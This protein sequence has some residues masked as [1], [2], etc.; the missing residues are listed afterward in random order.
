[1]ELTTIIFWVLM[2]CLLLAYFRYLHFVSPPSSRESVSSLTEDAAIIALIIIMGFVP[3]FGYITI[4]PGVSLTLLHLPLLVGA[5]R[6]DWK[7]GILYG[8]AF[9]LTSWFQAIQNAAGL[10][11][12]F[13]YP[14]VSVLPRALFG[15]FAGLAF[16]FL[17]KGDKLYRN[18]FVIAAISF[19][20]T[21][22][23]TG[24]VFAD[25]FLFYPTEMISFFSLSSS[26]GNGIVVGVTVI[27][28]LGS[29][30]EAILGA[31]FT[32]IVTKT[33]TKLLRK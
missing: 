16:F 32:P 10:N 5:Y 27:L 22:L 30:G 6:G 18:G 11:A 31:I 2:I 25:L 1:M 33:L 9:G 17:K 26:I 4:V 28:L 21:L 23:H 12:F 8:V 13:V 14:W 20:L 29:L 3:Q 7:R 19:A 24:L 15:F